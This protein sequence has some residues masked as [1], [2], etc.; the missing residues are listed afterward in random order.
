M[1]AALSIL[2]YYRNILAPGIPDLSSIKEPGPEIPS[3]LLD[4]IIHLGLN[5]EWKIKPKQLDPIKLELRSKVGPNGQATVCSLQDLSV[6][7]DN[8]YN[9]L[10]LIISRS[11]DQDNLQGTLPRL[12]KGISKSNG[13]HSRLAIKREKG[14]KDRV[15]AMVDYWT[16]IVLKPLHNGLSKILKQIPEDCTFDQGA[17][18]NLM[19]EWTL[20]GNAISIDLTSASDRFPLSLQKRIMEKLV[21]EEFSQAWSELMVDR[22]FTY[23]GKPYRWSVGQPLGA[24]SSWPSFALAHHVVMRA[25]HSKAGISHKD[26]YLILGDDMAAC[27]SKAIPYYLN[28]LRQLGVET[29]STKGLKGNSC[30]FAKRVFW[31]GYEVSPVPVPMLEAMLGDYCLLPEFIAK[32]RERSSD[33]QLDLRVPSFIAHLVDKTNWDKEMIAILSSYPLPRMRNLILSNGPGLDPVTHNVTWNG[34]TVSFEKLWEIFQQVR[35]THLLRQL[36]NLTRD[37]RTKFS[38][39]NQVELPA[40]PT[41]IRRQHPIF[42]A[43]GNYFDEVELAREEVRSFLSAPDWTTEVPSVHLTNVT[44]LL[45]GSK[46]SARHSG[47]LLLQVW[48]ELKENSPEARTTVI[49]QTVIT[50]TGIMNIGMKVP[51]VL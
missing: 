18:V 8:L 1:Q 31:R 36:D 24:H 25:A 27:D 39:L 30:E 4:E 34:I 14:G 49:Y 47:K 9:N 20:N 41:G 3:E 44:T 21:D 46:A 51:K 22:D 10:L 16:Q 2:G 13:C 12:R 17:G 23:K 28:Y 45:K 33:P 35:Y 38:A 11:S 50:A 7:P 6:L 19:K 40:T 26:Q 29:S 42:Y 15:F 32:L 48:K 37:A 5:P 43:Y